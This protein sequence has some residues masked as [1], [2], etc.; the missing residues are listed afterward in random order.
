MT[1]LATI[2][3]SV[4]M[5]M[6]DYETIK[7]WN[8]SIVDK[9]NNLE[10]QGVDLDTN[11]EYAYFMGAQN[12]SNDVLGLIEWPTNDTI[13]NAASKAFKNSITIE[14]PSKK[15]M[16]VVGFAVGFVIARKMK[17]NRKTREAW[18]KAT[19]AAQQKFQ[20][21]KSTVVDDDEQS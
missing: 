13:A 6:D 19:N 16:V 10:S 15:T 7:K 14:L 12:L 17:K 8:S 1:N 2:N 3:G 5:S 11:R 21:V 18:E 4:L 9:L 20:V